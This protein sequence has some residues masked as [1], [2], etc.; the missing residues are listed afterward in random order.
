MI[1]QNAYRDD[2]MEEDLIW[3]T[4]DLLI[5]GYIRFVMRYSRFKSLH[6]IC[7]KIYSFYNYKYWDELAT[8][9]VF[10]VS[11]GGRWVHNDDGY[12]I[13]NNDKIEGYMKYVSK[14]SNEFEEASE[15]GPYFKIISS[16]FTA[17]KN[18]KIWILEFQNRSRKSAVVKMGI[19]DQRIKYFDKSMWNESGSNGVY[20]NH[21]RFWL[22]HKMSVVIFIGV[23]LSRTY[24]TNG[25]LLFH[26][27]NLQHLENN[28]QSIYN[29]ADYDKLF[30]TDKL[31]TNVDV[32]NNYNLII[33]TNGEVCVGSMKVIDQ[34]YDVFNEQIQRYR[35]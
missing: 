35:Y 15:D 3:D 21:Y 32:N 9:D 29:G 16:D 33:E 23:D 27:Q 25:I 34:H 2:E 31:K 10:K 26:P 7:Q 4:T 12:L 14:Y 20:D 11:Y 8:D 1:K 28:K 22:P 6:G 19:I 30:S 13:G 24:H 17:R 5:Y 18:R